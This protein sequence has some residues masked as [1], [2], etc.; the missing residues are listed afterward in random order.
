MNLLTLRPDF[1]HLQP[2]ART[3]ARVKF[4]PQN[5]NRLELEIRF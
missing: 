3:E 4:C 5:P 1:P 2:W